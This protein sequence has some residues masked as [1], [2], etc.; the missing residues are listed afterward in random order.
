M[1]I[2]TRSGKETHLN[3][4]EVAT[5]NDNQ[6]ATATNHRSDDVTELVSSGADYAI[7]PESADR[8]WQLGLHA[9]D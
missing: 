5:F 2:Q 4:G 3:S 7:D 1:K 9:T 8:L 6:E